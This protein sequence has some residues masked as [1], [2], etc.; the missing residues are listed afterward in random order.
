MKDFIEQRIIEAVRV[1]LAGR[2]NEILREMKISIPVIEFGEHGC[3]YAV[4]PVITLS[5]CERTEKERIIRLDS[6]SLTITFEL[7]DTP[8]SESHCY[9]YAG[10]VSRALYYDPTLGG[11]A[12]RAVVTG[13]KYCSPKKPNCGEGWG[14]I[15]TLRVTVEGMRE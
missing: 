1:L 12:D 7:S 2:V 14:L 9:T 8:E 13:K 10:V 15:L 11:V 5:L 3:G 6:Y 4:A